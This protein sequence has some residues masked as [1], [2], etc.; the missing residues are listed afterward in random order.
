MKKSFQNK[1]QSEIYILGMLHI[2]TPYQ[3][4]GYDIIQ[5][6]VKYV[7]FGPITYRYDHKCPLY[8]FQSIKKSLQNKS[9]TEIYILGMFHPVSMQWL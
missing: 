8:Q 7:F 4:N 3:C 9:Q 5:F 6:F 1:P 2:C